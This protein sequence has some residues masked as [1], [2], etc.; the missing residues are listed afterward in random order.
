MLKSCAVLKAKEIFLV[1]EAVFFI[2][3]GVEIDYGYDKKDFKG[4]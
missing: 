1:I 3:L 2:E 4:C